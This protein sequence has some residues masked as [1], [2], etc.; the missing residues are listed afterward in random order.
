MF[1]ATVGLDPVVGVHRFTFETTKLTAGLAFIV[2]MIGL[3]GITEGLNHYR[4]GIKREPITQEISG[5]IPSLADLKAIRNVSLGSSIAGGLIG[6]IPGAGGDMASFVTYNEA[7][8]W[9]RNPVPDL[10]EGNV[11][12]VAAAEAGNNAST[13]GALIPTLTLGIPGDAVSAILIGALLVHGITPGPGMFESDA[14]IA[15]GMFI[16]FFLVYVV[17]L[18]VGLLGAHVW[19]RLISV[20]PRLLWPAILVLCVVGSIALRGSPFDAWVMIVAGVVGY[21]LTIQDYPLIPMV[22]G[23]ILSPIAEQNFRRSMQLSG[24]SYDIF[25]PSPIAAA[26]LLLAA[27]SLVYPFV[28]RHWRA[29]RSAGSS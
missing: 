18:V 16:G 12:G 15:Y 10:G 27:V 17:I 29:R 2:V 22:L 13:G 25:Y 26:I 24:G 20:P 5:V 1:I 7:K 9:I 4:K 3:F 19:V 11:K 21:V 23:M 8:R 6:A 14:S 28:H